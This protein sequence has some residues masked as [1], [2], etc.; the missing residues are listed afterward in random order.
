MFRRGLPV[1]P[2]IV[3]TAVILVSV[4]AVAFAYVSHKGLPGRDYSYVTAAVEEVPPGMRAGSEVRIRGQRVGQV[5][6]I[7]FEDGEARV[8]MQLPGGLE[9][10]HDASVRI[11]S[12]SML[13]QKYVQI[14]PGTAGAGPLGDAIIGQDRTATVVD[15]VDLVDTLDAPTRA[16]LGSAISELGAGV[17]GRGRDLNDLIA[18]SPDLLADT[19]VNGRTLTAEETRLVAFLVA[20]ERLSGRFAGREAQLEAL[21]GQMG[22]TLAAVAVDDGRPLAEA[23]KR[24]PGTLEALTPAMRDLGAAAATLGPAVTDLGPGASALG[25]VTPDMRAFFREALAPLRK[26]PGVNE[27]ATPAFSALT[28]TFED[29]RPLAPALRRAFAFSAAQLEL[30]APYAADLDLMLD[31][32]AEA[33]SQ[34]DANGHYLRVAVVFAAANQAENRNPYPEPG[35]PATDGSRYRP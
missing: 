15:I 11:R 3:G 33:F 5:R 6:D 2:L 34:G 23:V 21:M 14:D 22:D 7:S 29:A 27:L 19:T 24:L 1:H 9:V 12:R 26:A 18:A 17:G 30:F 28:A 4:G 25:A 16:A 13:G 8:E 35:E 10:H 32:T 31:G 20:A